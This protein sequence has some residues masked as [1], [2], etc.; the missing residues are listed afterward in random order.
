[1]GISSS[2][3]I[4]A[5]PIIIE[6]ND[7]NII[8]SSNAFTSMLIIISGAFFQPIFGYIIHLNEKII[9]NNNFFINFDNGFYII[10]LSLIISFIMVLL[11]FDKISIK[12]IIK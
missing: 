12:Y 7:I 10:I 3:Q 1:M 8:A 9:I 4:I 5:Y 6:N 11:I 2:A